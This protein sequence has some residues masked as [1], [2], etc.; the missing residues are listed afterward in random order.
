VGCLGSSASLSSSSRVKYRRTLSSDI[1]HALEL[2]RPCLRPLPAVNLDG[3]FT[4]PFPPAARILRHPLI[5]RFSATNTL[6][7][8]IS[9]WV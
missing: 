5:A 1:G 8:T 6:T 4:G 2:D 3:R 7:G 9:Y